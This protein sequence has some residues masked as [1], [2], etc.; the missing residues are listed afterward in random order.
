MI[1]NNETS[2]IKNTL[3]LVWCQNDFCRWEKTI[4]HVQPASQ[5][6]IIVTLQSEISFKNEVNYYV[7]KEN[8]YITFFQKGRNKRYM[9]Y[10]TVLMM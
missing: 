6:I 3:F 2:K 7:C 9:A 8:K 10:F 5:I 4:K 1:K